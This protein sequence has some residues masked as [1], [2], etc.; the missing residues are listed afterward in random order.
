[1]RLSILV[2]I[3]ITSLLLLVG[4]TAYGKDINLQW[5]PSP[6]NVTGYA[7][8]YGQVV[9]VEGGAWEFRK[10]VGDVLTTSVSD[11]GKGRWYFAVTAYNDVKESDFSNIVDDTI[12]GFAIVDVTHDPVEK[13]ERVTITIDVSR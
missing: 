9:P 2:T 7:L 11:L 8:Y 1:M 4:A 5:D 13:P 3:L 12:E 6:S 10:D